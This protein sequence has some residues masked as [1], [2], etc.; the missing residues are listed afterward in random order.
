MTTLLSRS[1]ILSARLPHEDVDVP[2]WGGGVRIQQMSV[3]VRARYLETIR[4]NQNEIMAYEDD[5]AAPVKSRKRLAKP[6]EVDSA[7]L[8]I[9]MSLV[10]DGGKLLLSIAD[11]PRINQ[12]SFITVRTLWE[13]VLR[14]NQLNQRASDQV[15]AEKKG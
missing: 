12:L 13:A 14:I 10:D 4:E 2:E 1:A 3:D 15:E 9:V 6:A 7:A 5:Q 8:G 11:L